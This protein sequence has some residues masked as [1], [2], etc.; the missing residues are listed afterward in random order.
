VGCDRGAEI[1]LAIFGLD[2]ERVEVGGWTEVVRERGRAVPSANSRIAS[3]TLPWRVFNQAVNSRGMLRF[4]IS[5]SNPVSVSAGGSCSGVVAVADL[6][7]E[8]GLDE[9]DG[10]PN[11]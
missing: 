1:R 2:T 8:L 11:N 7:L 4:P 5:V 3:R 9:M 10:S 6:A